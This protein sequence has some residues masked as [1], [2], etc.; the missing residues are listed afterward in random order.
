[1]KPTYASSQLNSFQAIRATSRSL[2]LTNCVQIR[3]EDKNPSSFSLL[4]YFS[5]PNIKHHCMHLT[6]H[7]IYFS[8]TFIS[9]V[10]AQSIYFCPSGDSPFLLAPLSINNFTASI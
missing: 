7:H 6:T 3:C 9:S 2:S 4:V 5:L 10:S 8:S 1:M